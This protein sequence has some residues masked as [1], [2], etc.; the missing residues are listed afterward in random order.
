M[1]GPVVLLQ[2]FRPAATGQFMLF[3]VVDVVIGGQVLP[4]DEAAPLRALV[5]EGIAM[6]PGDVP[7]VSWLVH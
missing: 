2:R 4:S 5:S 3:G 6:H 7:W 1:E